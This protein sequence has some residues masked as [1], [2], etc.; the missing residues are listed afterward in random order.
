[1]KH[2][3]SCLRLIHGDHVPS[4]INSIKTEIFVSL[5]LSVFHF[6]LFSCSEFLGI[7]PIQ[8]VHPVVSSN[9]VANVV[10]VSIINEYRNISVQNI[11]NHWSSIYFKVEK[12]SKMNQHVTTLPLPSWNIKFFLDVFSVQELIQF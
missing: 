2:L 9:P 5:V 7:F 1:M 6:L 3:K 11:F 10:L 12:E 8:I 4:I